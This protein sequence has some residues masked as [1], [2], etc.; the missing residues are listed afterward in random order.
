M[1]KL[2]SIWLDAAPC[3][4]RRR[5]A[6]LLQPLYSVLQARQA[7]G[8]RLRTGVSSTVVCV[9]LELSGHKKHIIIFKST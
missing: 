3:G 6:T 7:V 1:F 2:H 5:A 9:S 4:C 8:S